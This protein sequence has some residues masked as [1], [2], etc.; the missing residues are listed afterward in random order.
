MRAPE[1]TW[2]VRLMGAI[3]YETPRRVGPRCAGFPRLPSRWSVR[4][5]PMSASDADIP[6]VG[7][8]L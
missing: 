7:G 8:P 5:V 3:A 6:Q 1:P 4:R 2:K